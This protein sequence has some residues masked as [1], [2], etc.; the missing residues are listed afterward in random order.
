MSKSLKST[1]GIPDTQTGHIFCDAIKDFPHPLSA[2]VLVEQDLSFRML[3]IPHDHV[4]RWIFPKSL[5]AGIQILK[6]R[7]QIRI[8]EKDK[9]TPRTQHSAANRK[10][11][12]K[13][14]VMGQDHELGIRLGRV[15]GQIERPV[16]ARLN[17]DDDFIGETPQTPM[18]LNSLKSGRQ[19]LRFIVCGNN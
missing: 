17:H 4:N 11:F 8:R 18:F 14:F 2:L 9:I 1:L 15:F 6:W 5:K 19:P 16:S 12:S 13:P 7:A 10:A 3:A